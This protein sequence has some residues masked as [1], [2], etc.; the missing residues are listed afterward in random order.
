MTVLLNRRDR[1]LNT[2][3]CRNRNR[4]RCIELSL[5]SIGSFIRKVRSQHHGQVDLVAGH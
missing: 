2:S 4:R 1:R 3:N 5:R